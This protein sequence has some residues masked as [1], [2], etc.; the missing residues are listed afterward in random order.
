MICRSLK[1]FLIYD[2]WVSFHSCLNLSISTLVTLLL[3]RVPKMWRCQSVKMHCHW[4]GS[5][6]STP[7]TLSGALPLTIGT[8]PGAFQSYIELGCFLLQR[9]PLMTPRT[10]K[11]GKTRE[12]KRKCINKSSFSH[13]SLS[14]MGAVTAERVKARRWANLNATRV[15]KS[16]FESRL[17]EQHQSLPDE[18]NSKLSLGQVL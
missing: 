12:S 6:L 18:T 9:A 5:V 4:E 1:Y 15:L 3:I 16:S 17:S 8:R 13:L 10:R 2:F 11:D 14:F 7:A